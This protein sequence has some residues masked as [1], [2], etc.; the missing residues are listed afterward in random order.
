MSKKQPIVFSPGEQ[1][2]RLTVV[3]RAPDRIIR[4]YICQCS[5]GR[6]RMLTSDALKRGHTRS[7]G[8][9]RKELLG[10]RSRRHGLSQTKA[11]FCWKHMLD[12]CYKSTHPNYQNYGARGI[13]VCD[14]WRDSLDN[15][16]AD[17]GQ[18]PDA[19]TLDR[20]NNNGNY[21]PDNCKWRTYTQQNRN[22]RSNTLLTFNGKTQCLSAWSEE[23]GIHIQTLMQ[24]RK[25]GW[26]VEFILS[27]D[28][29]KR[30]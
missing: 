9:L 2:G 22:L 23:L 1:I 21:E 27:T 26:P 15:F 28:R 11:Y 5:C 4:Q 6:V 12:R 30:P 29:W 13:T 16:I 17:M 24:R 20:T 14:R 3:R 25:K 7:C 8:C 18:P 10:K 19:H